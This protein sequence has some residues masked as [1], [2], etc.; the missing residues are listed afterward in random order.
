LLAYLLTL[1]LSLTPGAKTGI[2]ICAICAGGPLGLKATQVA[3]GAL[4]WSLSMTVVLL[5]LNMVTLPLW[6]SLLIDGPVTLRMGDLLGVLGAAILVPV[7]VGMVLRPRVPDIDRWFGFL[8]KA[9]NSLLVLAVTLGV[10]ANAGG[11]VD[12]LSSSLLLAVVAVVVVAG[13]VAWLVPDEMG[14]RRASTLGTLNRATSVALLIVGRVFLD[15]TE[16]FTTV[17]LFGLIQTVI[18]IGLALYWGVAQ[19]TST[20]PATAT[21]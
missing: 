10:A 9:S 4:T 19:S 5:V 2:L 11:L 16:I 17:V 1:A 18:A 15:Q 14:R 13:G 6:S 8:S 21:T 12:S 3:R 20:A 7:A